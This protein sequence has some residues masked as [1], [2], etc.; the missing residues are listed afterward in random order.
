VKTG[1][2]VHRFTDDGIESLEELMA[3]HKDAPSIIEKRRQALAAM[4]KPQTNSQTTGQQHR[5]TTCAV[6]GSTTS[7][8]LCH[9]AL[10]A[11][12]G[13]IFG[14]PSVNVCGGAHPRAAKAKKGN[15]RSIK[16]PETEAAIN[17]AKQADLAATDTTASVEG[18][19]SCSLCPNQIVSKNKL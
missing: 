2:D 9:K 13:I 17:H 1:D 10:R 7:M 11:R 15:P 19:F 4:M 8:K 5:P 12:S 14:V 3:I 16:P 18:T 6:A